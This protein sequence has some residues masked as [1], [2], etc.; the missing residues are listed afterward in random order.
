MA[1]QHVVPD[2]EEP[3]WIRGDGSSYAKVY[4]L[5]EEGSWWSALIRRTLYRGHLDAHLTEM[6]VPDT[7]DLTG[8]DPISWSGT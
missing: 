3:L 7:P 6:T 2:E 5:D 8:C 4:I 1:Q